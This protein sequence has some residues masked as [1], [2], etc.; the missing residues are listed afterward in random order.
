MRIAVDT[1]PIGKKSDSAHKVRG[2]GMYINMLVDN[3]P[4][5]DKKNEY[6]FFEGNKYPE[7]V[8]LVHYP[9]FD[10]FFLTLPSSIKKKFAVTVHDLTPL[11][12]KKNF[13]AG[14]KGNIR[15]LLQK[16]RL[17]GAG[18]V[19]A[20]S[21]VSK[22][23]IAKIASIDQNKIKVVYLAADAKLKKITGS[24]W[25]ISIRKKYSLPDNFL[26]YVGDATW[27]KN[28][29]NLIEAI[30]KTD[31]KLVMVGKVWENS[32][33]E[34]LNHPWNNDLKKTLSQVQK[35]DRF[36]RLGFVPTEDLA[37]IYNLSTALLMPSIYEGFG[38]PVLEAMSCGCPVICSRGGSLP[39]VGA[40]A[41]YYMDGFDS[42]SIAEAIE[43]VV[44][45]ID[46]QK[47]LSERGLVQA[48]KFSIEK[49][50]RSLVETY[51]GIY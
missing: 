16:K 15:W 27:N 51:E 3:L 28:L 17:Q 48:K 11:V 4:K 1:S 40:E 2:V 32:S 50:I 35:D 31:S 8:D 6:I 21:Q 20:D 43:K 23:D 5:F 36:I 29:P 47:K 10:P 24:S 34:I 45:G 25:K 41:A 22:S 44:G 18:V 49:S 42:S 37:A 7:N 12:F 46:L 33:T 9:Y 38:L 13:P 14:L 30:Q 19:I 26:L 39:E